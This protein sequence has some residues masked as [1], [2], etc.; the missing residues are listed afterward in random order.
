MS[1]GVIASRAW[2]VASTRASLVRALAFL[3]MPFT[4]EKASSMGLRSGGTFGGLA[5]ACEGS[6]CTFP[7]GLS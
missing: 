5:G 2:P 1:C 7:N 4:F 3:K 6:F